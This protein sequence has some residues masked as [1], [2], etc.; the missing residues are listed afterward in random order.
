MPG[1]DPISRLTHSPRA[2]AAI[3]GVLLVA[4]IVVVIVLVTGGGSSST[5]MSV[6]DKQP[7]HKSVLPRTDPHRD[8]L[9]TI[10]TEGS[11]I[12][13][14][15]AGEI[16]KLHALGV[17]RVRVSFTWSMIAP[18]PGSA[19]M[20]AHFDGADPG[21]YPAKNWA[22]FDQIVRLLNA[23]HMG[24]DLVLAPPPPLWAAGK[25]A[26]A[27]AS[28]H[29]Y[30]NPNPKLFAQFVHAVGERYSGHYT[31]KGDSSPLP[32][33]DFWSIWNEPNLGVMLAPQTVHGP[34]VE[35][36]PAHYRALANAAWTSLQQ[37]GHGHDTTLLGELAPI[38]NYGDGKPGLFAAMSPLRFLRVL[39]CL[40][41]K[42]KPFTGHE[43]AVRGCPTTA[44]ASKRFAADNPVLFHATDYAAHPYPYGLAPNVAVPVH[45]TDDAVLGS[46]QH[47]FTTLDRSVAA[48]GSHRRYDVYDT[49]YGYITAPPATQNA[50]L[51][52]AKAAKWLNW[53]EYIT[54]RYP[55]LLSYDQYLLDDPSPTPGIPYRAFASGLLTY[56]GKPKPTLAAFRVPIWMPKT[57]AAKGSPLE[58]WGCVR[59][60]K[61][62]ASA[63]RAPAQIQ[64]RPK[65]GHAWKTVATAST[66][67]RYGYL[68]VHAKFPSSGDVRISW[69]PSGGPAIVSRTTPVTIH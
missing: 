28:T 3:A 34:T 16:D 5:P 22:V 46:I 40:D 49:E 24:L 64:F 26:P 62:T 58:V 66:K 37:T 8:D 10:F 65:G 9:Q 13:N 23:K 36:S 39:Y 12:Y 11:A 43:A 57:S 4:A 7:E 20:P 55:R 35:S 54:W 6:V 29:P 14:D 69:K 25:G 51:K 44:A 41:T 45:G 33:E 56:N 31:P 17:D 18:Q 38:G 1:S 53:S 42:F 61:L 19:K 68:D 67:T 50:T 30:W 59:P 47:L 27:P 63:R 60:A 2:L 32:R 15:P 52:P 48:Y 21:A